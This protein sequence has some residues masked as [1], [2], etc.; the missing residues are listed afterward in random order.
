MMLAG[1]FT[2]RPAIREDFKGET[3]LLCSGNLSAREP[4]VRK[5][6]S[7]MRDRT[8]GAW[9][10]PALLLLLSAGCTT[11]QRY[12]VRPVIA[13]TSFGI[14]QDSVFSDLARA[15][16]PT[17]PGTWNFETP[18]RLRP[19]CAFGTELGARVGYLPIAGLKIENIVDLHDLGTHQYNNGLVSLQ[20]EPSNAF[21]SS[22]K[23][24]LIYTCRGAFI[25]TAHVRD[26]ADW[27]VYLVGRI[28]PMVDGG[29]IIVLPSEG[30]DRYL[31]VGSIRP[32]LIEQLGREEIAIRLAQWAT[33]HL[34]IW[35]E[36]AT[37]Y[38]W[39]SWGMF[40]ETASAF[41][42]ED[43]YSDLVGVLLASELI[44]EDLADNEAQYNA[45]MNVAFPEVLRRLGGAPVNVTR[46]AIFSVD[47]RWWDSHRLL[48]DKEV[49][50]RRSFDI[51]PELAPWKPPMTHNT[52]SRVVRDYCED[53]RMLSLRYPMTIDDE[54]LQYMVRLEVHPDAKLAA[55]VGSQK[56][57]GIW[58]SQEE[59]PQIVKRAHAE[60]RQEF[61]VDSDHP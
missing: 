31:Y 40:P 16:G 61:G 12:V 18:H 56:V 41:S 19:C 29:G 36:T 53:M 33:I 32:D 60:N 1:G 50:I 46:A 9:L 3:Q 24:G 11:A 57:D 51:G 5:T 38:G 13:L 42:P 37:W 48:P 39:S 35:H 47:G 4:T 10:A 58:V 26:H 23:N 44:R 14:S 2:K 52:N 55:R 30:G 17:E 43:I 8:I 22:E 21:I 54:P 6:S 49:V 15:E 28:R 59:F 7:V 25:D 34:A 20:N 27:M 45:A